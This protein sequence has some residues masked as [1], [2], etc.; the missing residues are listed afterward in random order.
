MKAVLCW[1]LQYASME[2]SKSEAEN[3]VTPLRAKVIRLSKTCKEKVKRF[4]D[5]LIIN[6]LIHW[7]M[8]KEN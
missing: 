3:M 2:K 7:K 1:P 6:I 4:F 5:I 8:R